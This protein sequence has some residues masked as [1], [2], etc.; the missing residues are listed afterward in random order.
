MQKLNLDIF[1]DF[2][3]QRFEANYDNPE[4]KPTGLALILYGIDFMDTKRI[5]NMFSTPNLDARS[6]IHKITWI[7]DSNCRVTFFSPQNAQMILEHLVLDLNQYKIK[8]E[9]DGGLQL[10]KSWFELKPYD[11]YGG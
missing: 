2:L 8:A 9:E 1:K 11:I 7:N 6:F 10:P 3:A 4:T 5:G